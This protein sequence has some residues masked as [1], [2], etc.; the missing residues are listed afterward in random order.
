MIIP[1]SEPDLCPSVSFAVFGYRILKH[2]YAVRLYTA[3][4]APSRA[5]IDGTS[6][7][8]QPRDGYV[9]FE[10]C[11]LHF[12]THC[13]FCSYRN[14][15]LCDSLAPLRRCMVNENE[16]ALNMLLI[17]RDDDEEEAA[18]AEGDRKDARANAGS[19]SDSNALSMIACSAA[20]C[21][22]TS[23]IWCGTYICTA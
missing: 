23:M 9:S 19:P 15:V 5:F 3:S 21:R 8:L 13:M 1:V 4:A 16:D 2:D 11:D 7:M 18:A 14:S 6:A 17:S 20:A 10:S 22:T 12:Q